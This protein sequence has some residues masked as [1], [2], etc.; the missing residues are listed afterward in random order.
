[1]YLEPFLENLC[2]KCMI[3]GNLIH[4]NLDTES[5]ELKPN[6]EADRI[7]EI[8]EVVPS[9]YCN[10]L[11]DIIMNMAIPRK[12]DLLTLDTLVTGFRMTDLYNVYLYQTLQFRSR[13]RMKS[14]LANIDK[15]SITLSKQNQSE[16]IEV[17][18]PEMNSF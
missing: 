7:H 16:R 11:H 10:I 13:P 15:Q 9:S 4:P 2:R 18:F 12:D 3:A 17:S 5:I 14:N 1:M 6:E 8:M